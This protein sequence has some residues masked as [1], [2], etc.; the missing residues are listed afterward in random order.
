MQIQCYCGEKVDTIRVG[1]STIKT[2][3]SLSADKQDTPKIKYHL[4]IFG[5]RTK[6]CLTRPAKG[7]SVWGKVSDQNLLDILNKCPLQTFFPIPHLECS[8]TRIIF[9]RVKSSKESRLPF[10]HL[11][12]RQIRRKNVRNSSGENIS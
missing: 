10:S 12:T 8:F 7:Q 1:G 3:E 2:P 6:E 11:R 5:L 4:A 9:Q